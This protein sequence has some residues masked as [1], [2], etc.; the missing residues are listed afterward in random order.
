M[1]AHGILKSGCHVWTV[2]S[3]SPSNRCMFHVVPGWMFD[4]SDGFYDLNV[5][6]IYLDL[7]VQ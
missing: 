4:P 1:K 3:P 5:S 2:I 6:M 7:P